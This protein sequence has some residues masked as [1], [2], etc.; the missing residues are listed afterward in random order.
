MNAARFPCC[1]ASVSVSVFKLL[2]SKS[3]GLVDGKH[4]INTAEWNCSK[5]PAEP[6]NFTPQDESETDTKEDFI[7]VLKLGF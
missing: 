1:T 2:P 6:G 7:L 5:S 4:L 3:D